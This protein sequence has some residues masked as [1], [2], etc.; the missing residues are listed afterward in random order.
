MQVFRTLSG[1]AGTCALAVAGV[2]G[3]IP[4]AGPARAEDAPAFA[5][6]FNI[7]AF[8]DYRFRGISQTA[9]DPAV[10]GG[11]DISYGIFYAGVWS[12]NLDFGTTDAGR[13]IAPVEVDLYAGIKPVLGP[14][15]FDFGVLYYAYPGSRDTFNGGPEGSNRI[16]YFEGKAGASMNPIKELTTGVT[17]YVSPDYTLE[18]GTVVSLEGTA[19]YA[20]PKFWVFD[21][22]ISGRIGYQHGDDIAYKSLISNGSDSYLYWD[23]GLT[24]TLEKFAF[25][26]RYIDTDI[27]NNNAA[28][29]FADT[30][31][32][33]PVAQCDS[34]FVFSVKTT[35]P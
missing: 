3:L 21:P 17:V 1:L 23:I 25:D 15:T 33:G 8:S 24:L 4:T 22:A 35:L 16:E 30:F 5:Y 7:G 10:Q 11:A 29:G 34:T 28:G 18:T 2:A 20:L 9:K 31:C 26:F 6:T 13:G 32:K 27:A 14:I 19:S 12:S